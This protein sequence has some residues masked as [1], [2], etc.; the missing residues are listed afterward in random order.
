MD[1][2]KILVVILAVAVLNGCIY[3]TDLGCEGFKDAGRSCKPVTSNVEYAVEKEKETEIAKTEHE[4]DVDDLINY[5]INLGETNPLTTKAK[6]LKVTILPYVD[7]T[8][9]LHMLSSLYIIIQKPDW[10]IG[11]YLIPADKGAVQ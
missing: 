11:D 4:K 6:T 9:R 7:D 8:G 5:S 2:Y 3:N 10:I 1:R